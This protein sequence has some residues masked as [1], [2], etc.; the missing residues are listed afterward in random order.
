[1]YSTKCIDLNVGPSFQTTVQYLLLIEKQANWKSSWLKREQQVRE[2]VT[3][4][5]AD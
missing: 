1:M 4:N 5:Q 2:T 3:E